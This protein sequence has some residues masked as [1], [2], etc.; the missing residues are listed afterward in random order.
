MSETFCP[1]CCLPQRGCI[2]SL[3]PNIGSSCQFWLLTHDLEH[4]KPSNTGKLIS[5]MWPET[6]II[7]WSRVSPDRELLALLE[8]QSEQVVLVF[9]EQYASETQQQTMAQ[10]TVTEPRK[11][12]FIII[13][14]TWQQARKIYRQSVYLQSLPLLSLSPESPSIYTLRRNRHSQ[15]LCTAEVAALVLKEWNELDQAL[16]LESL[17]QVYCDQYRWSRKGQRQV[18]ESRA[19]QCLQGYRKSEWSGIC[20]NRSK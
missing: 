6:R 3:V 18:T 8:D 20:R 19:L 15:H 1:D 5:A 2:C 13:D 7:N 16:L 4:D 10:Y 11:T 17:V 14:A 9:P 12:H